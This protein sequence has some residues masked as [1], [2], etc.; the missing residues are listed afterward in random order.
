MFFF[1]AGKIPL[2]SIGIY[3]IYTTERIEA[4]I[5]DTQYDEILRAEFKH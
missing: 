5:G 3:P 2:K 4:A 1:S